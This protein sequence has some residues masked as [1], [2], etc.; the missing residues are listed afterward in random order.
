MLTHES[1]QFLNS[2]LVQHVSLHVCKN[3]NEPE[4][5]ERAVHYNQTLTTPNFEGTIIYNCSHLFHNLIFSWCGTRK[6]HS[7]NRPDRGKEGIS[8]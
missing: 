2:V 8:N 4:F 6:Y 3:C 7:V 1:E 5:S